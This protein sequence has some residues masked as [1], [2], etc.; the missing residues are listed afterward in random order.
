MKK[1]CKLDIKQVLLFFGVIFLLFIGA[2]MYMDSITVP[3]H[4]TANDFAT[5]KI[6]CHAQPALTDGDQEA[7]LVVGFMAP[8]GW[9]AGQNTTVTYSGDKGDGIMTLMPKGSKDPET[10]LEWPDAAKQK[11]GIGGNLIDDVEW[12]VFVADRAVTASNQVTIKYDVSFKVKLGPNNL[13]VKLGFFNAT[14]RY[15]LAPPFNGQNPYY[16]FQF[17]DCFQVVGGDPNVDLEDMCHPQMSTV[18]PVNSLDN[19]IITLTFDNGLETTALSDETDIYVGITGYKT[20]GDTLRYYG[21]GPE[22]KLSPLGGKKF[23]IDLWPRGL[24]KVGK[25]E[26]LKR[27]VYRYSNSTGT[28]TVV[29]THTLTPFQYT[30]KCT[31]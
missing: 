16:A 9:N 14:L 12:V 8:K 15:G 10:K 1:V 7:T 18:T 28:K 20:N 23:R 5:F 3:D 4:G 19:D 2:C 27:L 29:N 6:T 31:N 24:L 25:N 21:I 22:T 26:T 11:M 17:S 30:F 13:F